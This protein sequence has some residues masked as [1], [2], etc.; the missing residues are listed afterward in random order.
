VLGIPP[1]PL[2]GRAYRYLLELRIEQG[3]LGGERAT[4]ELLR[5]A[6]AEGLSSPPGAAGPAGPPASE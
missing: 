6:E 5:W 4:Q 1:G 2:V 3:P